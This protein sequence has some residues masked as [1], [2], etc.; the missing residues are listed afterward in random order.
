MINSR[1][2]AEHNPE[3][4]DGNVNRLFVRRCSCPAANK[5]RLHRQARHAFEIIATQSRDFNQFRT[6]SGHCSCRHRGQRWPACQ[7]QSANRGARPAPHYSP[8]IATLPSLKALCKGAKTPTKSWHESKARGSASTRL[9]SSSRATSQNLKPSAPLRPRQP[10]LAK[11][12]PKQF[13]WHLASTS[14]R[15]HPPPALA[16]PQH[17]QR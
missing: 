16:A 8:G 11:H 5:P 13:V 12:P 2:L 3:A 10:L 6:V 1:G 14:I 15:Q 7:R 9:A 4:F 17:R